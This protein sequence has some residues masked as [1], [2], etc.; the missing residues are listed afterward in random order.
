M[1]FQSAVCC[2]SDG[3]EFIWPLALGR[4]RCLHFVSA[5]IRHGK[6]RLCPA[7]EIRFRLLWGW[8]FRGLQRHAWLFLG[9]RSFV[10]LGRLA[11]INS[12]LEECAIF[13]A[14]TVGNYISRERT[15][16]A[17]IHAITDIE[18]AAKVAHDHNLARGDSRLYFPLSSDGHT[19][20]GRADRPFYPPIDI[21]G[22]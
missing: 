5:S 17:N 4:L 8:N 22:L 1:D 9:F 12:A 19:M 14:D 21:K 2:V 15:V 16:A 6:A 20:G 18:I 7:I 11:N 3:N 13:Y 10:L